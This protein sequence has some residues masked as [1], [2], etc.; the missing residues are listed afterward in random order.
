[1]YT[2]LKKNIIF[3]LILIIIPIFVALV[4]GE[5]YA[6]FFTLSGYITPEI[7]KN[8]A[9]KYESSLFSK[10]VFPQKEHIAEGWGNL[11][12]YI[13]EKG[14][15]GRNFTVKKPKGIIRI[16]FYGGSSVF[17]LAMPEGKDW[18]R[19]VENILE[20]TGFPEVEVINAG[21][22]GYTS[23]DSFGSLFAE[24]HI[25]DPDY[26]VLY[27][28]WNDIKYF[29]MNESLLRHSRPYDESED[30]RVNYRGPVDRFL[31]EHSQLYVRLR[32]RYIKWLYNIGPEGSMRRE[33]RFSEIGKL[34]PKQYEVNINMFVDM[35]RNIGAEP[36]LMTQARLATRNN[37]PDQK[38]RISYEYQLLTHQALCAAFKKTD[39]IIR[40]IAKAKNVFLIDASKYLTGKDELF[41]DHTHFTDKGSEEL[42]N[43]TAR[44]IA[45]LLRKR[46]P[47]AKGI[48]E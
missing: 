47:R 15:R 11:K 44:H 9:L 29:R 5:I 14:Y 10:R 43:L 30:T 12:Y 33:K 42:A 38:E 3:S 7:K 41:R 25:F 32:H 48:S 19:R 35:A 31:C 39:E 4:L 26:V 27:N 13:N 17:D 37:T 23:T 40:H 20:A 36:I 16:I 24:G 6:R 2:T 1:M 28:A 18:P 21:I 22:P 34:G 8:R 46:R 45:E